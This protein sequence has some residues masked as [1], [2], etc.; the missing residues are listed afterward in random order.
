VISVPLWLEIL[1]TKEGSHFRHIPKDRK[2]LSD[3]FVQKCELITD[4]TD[5]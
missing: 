1:T 4:N 3:Q 5:K 2:E